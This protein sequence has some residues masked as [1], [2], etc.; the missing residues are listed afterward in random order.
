MLNNRD[1]IDINITNQNMNA[2]TNMNYNFMEPQTIQPIIEPMQE[3]IVNKTI[4]HQVPHI[5]PINT[6]IINNHV[7]KHT[8]CP[9]YT[10]CVENRVVPDNCCMNNF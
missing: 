1:D 5:C 10:C 3:R 9:R 4:V 2:N 6:R 7:Y 8:Y